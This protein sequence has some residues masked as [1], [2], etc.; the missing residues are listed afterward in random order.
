MRSRVWRVVVELA[1]A[2][3]V[4]IGPSMEAQRQAI[5]DVI[6]EHEARQWLSRTQ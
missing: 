2:L 4:P 1:R 6:A 5:H 3:R